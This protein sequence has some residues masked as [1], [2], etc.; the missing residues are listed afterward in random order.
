MVIHCYVTVVSGIV[1]YIII[2]TTHAIVAFEETIAAA[3]ASQGAF[4]A[5]AAVEEAVGSTMA[6]AATSAAAGAVKAAAVDVLPRFN[7]PGAVLPA[8]GPEAGGKSALPCSSQQR[9]L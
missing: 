2:P 3:I 9:A 4:D 8:V 6:A 5:N 1:L 7:H